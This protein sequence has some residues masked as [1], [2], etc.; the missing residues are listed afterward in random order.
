MSSESKGSLSTVHDSVQP[1]FTPFS[2]G[3]LTLPNRI[4]MAPM[5]RT[6]SPNGMPG[7][8]VAQYY[9]RRAENGVGLII[10]EGTVINHPSSAD[11]PNVPQF[12]GPAL[13]GWS[14]VVEQVHAAGGR[15]FAQLWHVGMARAVAS[16]PNPE[17]LPIGPSG[18]DLSGNQVTTPMTTSDILSV[19]EAFAQAAADAKLLGFDG[20]EI[21]GAHGYLI[22]QFFWNRTN[23]RTDR[24]GSDIEGRTRF[25]IEIIRAIRGAVGPTLPISLRISQWKSSNYTAKL[26]VTPKELASFLDPLTEAGVDIFHCSTRRFWEP[27]FEGSDLNLAGWVKSLTGRPTITV[28]SVGLNEEFTRSFAPGKVAEVT[29]LDGL[30]ERLERNEFDLVAVGRPLL[31]D[32]EWTLKVRKGRF[33]ELKPFTAEALQTLY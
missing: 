14:S 29:R 17:S 10:T 27:E 28:G 4:V 6:F 15:I 23:I 32:P 33:D 31:A 2:I 8:D 21:H 18:I 24:Y 12:Y 19:I 30:I 13:E 20:I 7:A 16:P 25:A 26:A 3:K 1:L 5:T 9:R 11:H 22:D